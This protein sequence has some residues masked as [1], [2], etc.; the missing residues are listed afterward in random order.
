MFGYQCCSRFIQNVGE[1]VQT[2]TCKF[3]FQSNRKINIVLLYNIC[4]GSCFGYVCM[5]ECIDIGIYNNIIANFTLESEK[6]NDC[7]VAVWTG[8]T[9]TFTI[10]NTIAFSKH[11]L[12]ERCVRHLWNWHSTTTDNLFDFKFKFSL[13][14]GGDD[15]HDW[16][17]DMPSGVVARLY[18]ATASEV[19]RERCVF[20]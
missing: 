9:C 5:H 10:K 16:M 17:Y 2:W 15:S 18:H 20:T 4:C 12:R 6:E 1:E 13:S 7:C 14:W 19:R 11:V 3:S 8:M